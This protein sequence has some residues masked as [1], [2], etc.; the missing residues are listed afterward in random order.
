MTTFWRKAIADFWQ[1]RTRTALVVIAIAL[2]VTGFTAVLSSYAILTRELNDD[3]LATNPASATLYTD[4]VDDTL[5]STI[6]ENPQVGTAEP[7]RVVTGKIKSGPAEWRNLV[8]FVIND[9]NNLRVSTV[10]H[11]QGAWPPATGEILIERDA[12]QVAKTKI[13]EH[14]TIKMTSGQEHTLLVSGGV[15]D[16]GQAQARMDNLVYGYITLATL[17]ELGEQPYLDQLKIVVANDGF[18]QAHIR[19]V[20]AGIEK[21]IIKNG[22]SVLK[23]DVP[24]P[25]EHPHTQI[26][27]ML[28]LVMAGFGVLVLLLSGVLVVNLLMAL[29]AAQIRQ[30]G[31]MKAIG[32]SRWQIAQIYFSQA[33]FLG[34]ASL[35]IA[36][37]AGLWGGRELCRFLGVFL[38]FD[39][40]SFAVPLWIFLLIAA[41]GVVTPL[42]AAAHPILKACSVS[43][44]TA[45]SDVGVVHNQY[46]SSWFDQLLAHLSGERPT[47]LF[48]LRNVFRRRTRLILTLITLSVAGVF[49]MAALNVRA[50][51]IDTLD[52]LFA[53][54]QFDLTVN[55]VGMAPDDAV[56]RAVSNTAG[57]TRAETWINADAIFSAKGESDNATEQETHTSD[58]NKFTVIALPEQTAMFK[59]NIIEGRNLLPGETDA[60]VVNHVLAD[61]IPAIKVGAIIKLKIGSEKN[62]YQQNQ[63]HVVGI[64]R[65]PFSSAAG[66]IPKAYYAATKP[67]MSNSVNLVLTRTD[68]GAINAVKADLERNLEQQG[69]H[70]RS[71]YT[72]GEGRSVIDEHIVMIYVFLIIMAG[73]VGGVGGL[74]LMT[75]MSLNVLERRREMGVLRTIGA[76]PR[77][78]WLIVAS[79]G[80]LIGLMSSVLAIAAAWPISKG[81]GDMLVGLMLRSV[82]DFRFDPSGIWIWLAV[83][84]VLAVAAS[85]MPAWQASRSSA[86]DALACE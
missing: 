11:E 54:R 37:P 33:L 18:N 79:E 10:Q 66:Y 28:L 55:F 32:G 20:A 41:I 36:V 30:I 53:T 45:L 26:M 27:G 56:T 61:K 59:P 67:N 83:S 31:V 71:N 23:I 49:F 24:V 60:I 5:L 7:R 64:A 86:R 4:K 15:H 22:H 74:G 77:T 68:E 58:E 39:I 43:V 57:I 21:I 9:F 42:L 78:V 29:M 6:L 51:M 2:G 81:I 13:G 80:A 48:A 8:L 76:T 34:L 82:L 84:V 40:N 1:E 63:W 38:N 35:L 12:F 85:F 73:I 70:A 50:S 16:V 19:E 52:H 65:E 69:I 46:R 25:G 44:R 47:L 17:A 14:V 62:G 3:Y 75:T 72:K